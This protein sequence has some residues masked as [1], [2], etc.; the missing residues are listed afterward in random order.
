MSRTALSTP[1]SNDA[2]YSCNSI[3]RQIHRDCG[4]QTCTCLER[5]R[6]DYFGTDSGVIVAVTSILSHV[7]LRSHILMKSNECLSCSTCM[8]FGGGNSH[9]QVALVCRQWTRC[10]GFRLA[11]RGTNDPKSH[12]KMCILALVASIGWCLGANGGPATQKE[13][14]NGPDTGL[15]GLMKVEVKEAPSG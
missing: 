14:F 10:P 11:N 13:V 12:V 7:L 3:K 1:S 8:A 15:N 5:E 2:N 4:G 6:R 9:S